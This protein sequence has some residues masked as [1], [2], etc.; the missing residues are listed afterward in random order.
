MTKHNLK[1]LSVGALPLV[2]LLA[3]GGAL[4]QQKY[5]ADCQSS[6]Y[7]EEIIHQRIMKQSPE[8]RQHWKDYHDGSYLDGNGVIGVSAADTSL[9]AGN[10]GT[11]Y[12]KLYHS[13]WLIEKGIPDEMPAYVAGALHLGGS[14]PP[15]HTSW[16]YQRLAK[17]RSTEAH[18]PY[19]LL[20]DWYTG[21][22]NQLAQHKYWTGGDVLD[23][24][25]FTSQQETVSL[26]APVFSPTHTSVW[27]HPVARA[28]VML[29]EGQHSFEYKWEVDE[30]AGGGGYGHESCEIIHTKPGSK[31]RTT[32]IIDCDNM[33]WH[34]RGV[35]RGELAHIH[36]GPYQVEREFLCDVAEHAASW[37]SKDQL[38]V[39][40]NLALARDATIKNGPPPSCGKPFPFGRTSAEKPV[41]RGKS[42]LCASD[43]TLCG[44]SCVDLTANANNCGMC[45]KKCSNGCID[46]AC[47]VPP[48]CAPPALPPDRTGKCPVNDGQFTIYN[49]CCHHV[50]LY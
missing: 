18:Y 9:R 7:A 39:A 3:S 50:I 46:R 31:E 42:C 15:W 38:V 1:K 20:V 28:G 10:S 5:I 43:M 17:A 47:F 24:L 34:N 13:H 4:G 37:V 29:H 12:S 22:I 45:G 25:G 19:I 35:A 33:E 49:G 40:F 6:S 27:S 36:D 48:T 21:P 16:D 44:G 8:Y 41:C 23:G 30:G 2:A 26:Y 11:F 14:S 32:R